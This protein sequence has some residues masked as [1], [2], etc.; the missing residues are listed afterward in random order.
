MNIVLDSLIPIR[1]AR[2][3][4]PITSKAAAER[5]EG[6]AETHRQ[7]VLSVL[8]QGEAGPTA[9]GAAIGMEPYA[10]RKRL[11][12]AQH[13]GEAEPTGR[14]ATTAS[15]GKERVWRAIA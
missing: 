13:L 11:A 12:D 7:R 4:D 10:V 6:F 5:A 15:G 2:R 9:I 1:R 8:R 3:T 14:T